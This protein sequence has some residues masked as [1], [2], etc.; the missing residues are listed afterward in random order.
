MAKLDELKNNFDQG[1]EFIKKALTANYLPP[2][3]LT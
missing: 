2:E 1:I 3:T